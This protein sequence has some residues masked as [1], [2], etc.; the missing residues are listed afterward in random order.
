MKLLQTM[1]TVLSFVFCLT[2]LSDVNAENQKDN[3]KEEQILSKD[4]NPRYPGIDKK[5]MKELLGKYKLFISNPFNMW[6][7]KIL[8]I[9]DIKEIVLEQAASS[10]PSYALKA[11][12]TVPEYWD[13]TDKQQ[14][15]SIGIEM[16][17]DEK[18]KKTSISAVRFTFFLNLKESGNTNYDFK[19]YYIPEKKV[20]SGIVK[21]N[22]QTDGGFI[23]E[24]IK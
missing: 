15:D 13:T 11:E 6:N 14:V 4:P 9:K 3:P 8:T 17:Y 19:A 18:K 5:Q 7:H 20:F 24:K 10:F 12:L 2:I 21:V 22:D 23:L 16:S 1:M